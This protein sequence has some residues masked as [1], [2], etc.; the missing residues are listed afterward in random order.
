MPVV[1]W[2]LS[3]VE[4]FNHYRGPDLALFE[5]VS[6]YNLQTFSSSWI[7]FKINSGQYYL[8]HK[9]TQ[10]HIEWKKVFFC[11][12]RFSSKCQSNSSRTSHS[13]NDSDLKIFLGDV[14]LNCYL[15]VYFCSS[16]IW[17]DFSRQW[18]FW[19]QN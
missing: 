7:I 14:E 12:E 6:V 9:A 13:G 15:F 3:W 16:K 17:G 19:G 18:G 2:I 8:L 5:I 11:K 4:F 10:H 1:W